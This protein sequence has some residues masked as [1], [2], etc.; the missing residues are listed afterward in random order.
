[1]EESLIGNHPRTRVRLKRGED[2]PLFSGRSV[3][4]LCRGEEVSDWRMSAFS[5][6]FGYL[7]EGPDCDYPLRYLWKKT[8]RTRDFR[9]SVT[10]GRDEGEE[11]FDL[12][13]DPDELVN[14]VNV[15]DYQEIRQKLKNEMQHRVMLQ[16]WPL[17]PRDLVT[18]VAN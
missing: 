14:L 7:C 1:M 13:T 12:R 8:L 11:L 15:P 3:M 9:Y 17:P 18:I 16:D 6:S 4:P 10:P 2:M 5:E